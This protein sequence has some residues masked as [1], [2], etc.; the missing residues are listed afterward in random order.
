MSALPPLA[1]PTPPS[2]VDDADDR[3]EW[4]ARRRVALHTIRSLVEFWRIQPHELEGELPTPPRAEPVLRPVKYRHPVTAETWDG[5]GAQPD[6]LRRALLQEGYTVAELRKAAAEAT[7]S[8]PPAGDAAEAA[9]ENGPPV[10]W[11][12]H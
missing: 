10:A 1:E 7:P 9:P 11:S 3:S 4:L 12:R 2:L 5:D 6:W 8:T